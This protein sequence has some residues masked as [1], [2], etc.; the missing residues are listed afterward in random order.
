MQEWNSRMAFSVT[1]ITFIKLDDLISKNQIDIRHHMP[2]F[3]HVK[4]IKK[5]HCSAKLNYIKYIT[6]TTGTAWYQ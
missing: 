5:I 2:C 1:E 4:Y 6:T 3:W